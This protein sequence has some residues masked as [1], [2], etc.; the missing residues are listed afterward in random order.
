MQQ[1]KPKRLLTGEQMEI[2]LDRGGILKAEM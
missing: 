2:P 1:R